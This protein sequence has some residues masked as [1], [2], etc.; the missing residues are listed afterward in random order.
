MPPYHPIFGHLLEVG[1][2]YSS[3]PPD[4]HPLYL[5]DQLRRK[6]P[7]M[8]PVFYVDMWPFAQPFLFTDSTATASQLM[9]EHPQMK[10]DDIRRFMYPL[11]KLNDLVSSEGQLWKD[12]RNALS[13]A[14]SAN[15]LISLLPQ[16]L[17]AVSTY[18]DVLGENAQS[19]DTFSLENA[20][21]NMTMEVI[22]TV[23]M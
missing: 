2:I 13:P 22:G 20:A 9:Q 11:T 14:F 21:I 17:E 8:G 12:W 15:N 18:V 3:I 19:Q 5:P 10:A 1:D 16:I 6:Y 4:A 7:N 23:T